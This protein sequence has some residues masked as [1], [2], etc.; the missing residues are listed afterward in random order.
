M[1]NNKKIKSLK[2]IKPGNLYR[3]MDVDNYDSTYKDKI[4]IILNTDIPP[5]DD[6]G[7]INIKYKYFF[8]GDGF[9]LD[10]DFFL[11]NFEEIA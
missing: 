7:S 2:S 4:V 9:Y 5:N 10:S 1:N 6:F 3:F 8:N 11:R